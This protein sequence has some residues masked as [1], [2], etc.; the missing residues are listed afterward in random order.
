MNIMIRNQKIIGRVSNF[1]FITDYCIRLKWNKLK[2]KKGWYGQLTEYISNSILPNHR[3]MFLL[4]SHVAQLQCLTT[5]LTIP[6]LRD[7]PISVQLKWDNGDSTEAAEKFV[8]KKDPIISG[9]NP[10]RTFLGYVPI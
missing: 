8:Y 5:P 9:V 10:L 7:Q 4:H 3:F 6:T 2:N 1:I